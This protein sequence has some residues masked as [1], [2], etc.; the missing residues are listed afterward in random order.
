MSIDPAG[1]FPLDPDARDAERFAALERRLDELERKQRP[2]AVVWR[3]GGGL[4]TPLPGGRIPFDTVKH[5]PYG[6][7]DPADPDH[8]TLPQAGLWVAF[9]HVLFD[10]G[11]AG[12]SRDAALGITPSVSL[13]GEHLGY[14]SAAGGPYVSAPSGGGWCEAGAELWLY[15]AASVASA[16]IVRAG[17]TAIFVG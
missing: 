11:A 2:Y 17:L 8:L 14:T 9:S 10:G 1:G 6:M 12:S 16:N 5:D 3:M 4:A 15:A 13:F 7:F